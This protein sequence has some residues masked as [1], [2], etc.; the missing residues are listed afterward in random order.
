MT[1]EKQIY[2][3]RPLFIYIARPKLKSPLRGRFKGNRAWAL[4]V[5]DEAMAQG[6]AET[7][8]MQTAVQQGDIVS[9]G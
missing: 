2:K 8:A 1:K 3:Q 4:P 9:N 6:C 5:A 7:V